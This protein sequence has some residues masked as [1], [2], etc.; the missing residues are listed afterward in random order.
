MSHGPATEWKEDE[1]ASRSKAKIGLWMF[2]GYTIVYSIFIVINV[3]NPNL[4]GLNMGMLNLAIV[5]GFGLIFLALILAL[6]YNAV[7]GYIEEKTLRI[8]KLAKKHSGEGAK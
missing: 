8:E 6:I 3:V 2:A 1:K 4:M 7:C 5:F